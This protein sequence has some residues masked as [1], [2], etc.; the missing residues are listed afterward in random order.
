MLKKT[1]L[2][3]T[4][5][6]TVALGGCALIVT[7]WLLTGCGQKGPLFMPPPPPAVAQP[8]AAPQQPAAT[9]TAPAVKQP[10]TGSTP[11]R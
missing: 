4:F 6:P 1:I 9:D 10:A 11:S 7:V 5:N 2:G 3:R 8:A